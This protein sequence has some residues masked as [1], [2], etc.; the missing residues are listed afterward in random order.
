MSA[1]NPRAYTETPDCV[2]PFLLGIPPA[3]LIIHKKHSAL[4]DQRTRQFL[5]GVTL[6][7]L[8]GHT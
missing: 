6:N 8:F 4:L 1:E 5:P 2:T 3:E 7:M